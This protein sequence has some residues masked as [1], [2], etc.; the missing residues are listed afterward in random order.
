MRPGKVDVFFVNETLSDCSEVSLRDLLKT[1]ETLS[2][3]SLTL[4]SQL[5][6]A[7]D[8]GR[9]LLIRLVNNSS[10]TLWLHLFRMVTSV[11]GQSGEART[12]CDVGPDCRT[13]MGFPAAG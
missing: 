13:G 8:T 5:V 2:Q 4:E 3:A 10:R 12:S 9:R 6:Q 7:P 1:T 11:R